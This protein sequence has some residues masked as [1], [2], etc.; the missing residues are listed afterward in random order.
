MYIIDKSRVRISVYSQKN[1]F[2]SR[3]LLEF[4]KKTPHEDYIKEQLSGLNSKTVIIGKYS[5]HSNILTLIPSMIRV[6]DFPV[7]S[8]DEYLEKNPTFQI[9]EDISFRRESE[10]LYLQDEFVSYAEY[11]PATPR[12]E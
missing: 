11:R 4:Q 9:K 5:E 8:A 6:D 2:K 1:S 12:H 10:I 7:M 3:N